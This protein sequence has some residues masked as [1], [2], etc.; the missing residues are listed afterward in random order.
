MPSRDT[1][2]IARLEAAITRRHGRL[3][4]RAR[5]L[6][7]RLLDAAGWPVL[8]TG[9]TACSG[10]TSPELIWARASSR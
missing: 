2:Q 6:R 1:L 4:Q 8:L 7:G 5:H 9:S 10:I 3:G